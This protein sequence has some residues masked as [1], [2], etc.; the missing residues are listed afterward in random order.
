MCDMNNLK[1]KKLFL[2]DI[3]GTIAV[4][5]TLFDGSAELISYIKSIG[6]AACFI[7]NNS[8]KSN[9]DYVKKFAECFGLATEEKQFATAVS[10]LPPVSAMS[11]VQMVRSS[12]SSKIK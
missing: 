5:N 4:G 11:W 10:S 2:F 7:T 1:K 3:D 6:G 9:D 12:L 8:T